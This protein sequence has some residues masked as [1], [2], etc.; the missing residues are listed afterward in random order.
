MEAVAV[1]FALRCPQGVWWSC[2]VGW[3]DLERRIERPVKLLGFGC[4]LIVLHCYLL[5][6][7]HVSVDSRVYRV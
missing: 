2:L 5:V 7:F 4:D 1:G 3:T 6:N